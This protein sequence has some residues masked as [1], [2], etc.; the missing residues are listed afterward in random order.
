MPRVVKQEAHGQP[1]SVAQRIDAALKHWYAAPVA[2]DYRHQAR[3][4]F[5]VRRRV[6]W[7]DGC[8]H[9]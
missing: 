8:R 1:V 9:W 3:R 2:A 5:V 6:R 4:V 7:G